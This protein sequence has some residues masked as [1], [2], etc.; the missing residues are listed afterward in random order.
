M[1][2]IESLFTRTSKCKLY[3]HTPTA[4]I[5]ERVQKVLFTLGYCW[6]QN[7]RRPMLLN[8]PYVVVYRDDTQL[9]I[10]D[11]YDGNAYLVESNTFL[12][13]NILKKLH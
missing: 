2:V 1:N 11:L 12:R 10:N 6:E 3:I 8:K 4:A 5:S 13:N 7:T 9:L